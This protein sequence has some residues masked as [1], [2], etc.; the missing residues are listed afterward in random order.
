MM[1]TGFP[2]FAA[3][4]AL[5]LCVISACRPL[6]NRT[7]SFGQDHFDALHRTAVS[8]RNAK[9]V[10]YVYTE[11][12]RLNLIGKAFDTPCPYARID[13]CVYKGFTRLEN[14]QCRASAGIAVAF[15]TNATTINVK[16]SWGQ[17][18]SSWHSTGIG[19]RGY[20][21]YIRNASGEWQ[22]AASG[23]TKD[24]EPDGAD[25]I[26][27]SG[28][29]GSMHECLMYLPMYSELKSCRIGIDEGA[30]IEP[31]ENPFRHKIVFHGSSYTQGIS[32]SRPG[33]TYPLQFER[34]T[35]LY[36]IPLGF[37]GN[38][39]MQPYFAD[40]ICDIE[41]DAY[42]FDAFS[43]PDYRMIEER[44]QPFIDALVAAHPGKPLIF[45]QTIYR[46][47]RNFSVTENASEQAK[48]D[49]AS[50]VFDRILRDPKY[51]DVYFIQA[52]ACEPGLHEYSVDGI[53]PDDHGYYLWSRSIEKPILAILRKYGIR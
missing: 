15:S 45:Q 51:K 33:M 14:R 35:G 32:V 53:H 17:P 24:S 5:L 20:D 48:Q 16:S 10:K 49:M 26:L 52:D 8:G 46:E 41:A 11:A 25:C 38:C 21:L 36:V 27:I 2:L 43:N 34:H 50:N 42:V 23:A 28:M 4:A 47:I 3:A 22:W 1:R 6:Y 7:Q 30:R 29:D 31:L 9:P 13:T 40:V 39:K 12:S 44:L 19:Y 18:Y 37:G